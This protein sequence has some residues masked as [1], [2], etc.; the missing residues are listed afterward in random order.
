[1]PRRSC[2]LKIIT[3]AELL[4]LRQ[5]DLMFLVRPSTQS[6][7]HTGRWRTLHDKISA[8]R[9]SSFTRIR[10]V[11]SL[12]RMAKAPAEKLGAVLSQ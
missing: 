7:G 1:M 12:E 4:I 5:C 8:R 10:L 6:K 11:C 3:M 2:L 9:N